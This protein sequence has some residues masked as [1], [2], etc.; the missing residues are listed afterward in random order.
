MRQGLQHDLNGLQIVMRLLFSCALTLLLG[1]C[2]YL[3]IRWVA[4][5]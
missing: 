4:G 1:L 3:A 2:A 5:A